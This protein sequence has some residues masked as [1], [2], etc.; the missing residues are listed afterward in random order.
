MKLMEYFFASVLVISTLC[1]GCASRETRPVAGPDYTYRSARHQL[2]NQQFSEPL[3]TPYDGNEQLRTVFLNGF[4][5]GW[6]VALKY[7]LGNAIAIPE[8]YQKS[9]EMSKAW[10]EGC[11]A[12]Q[13]ALYEQVRSMPVATS[14]SD[15]CF[16]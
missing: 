9:P 4:K 14:G 13:K 5:K 3:V 12:G 15:R 7:W 10:N 16:E 1:D 2:S 11:N 8:A 6:D